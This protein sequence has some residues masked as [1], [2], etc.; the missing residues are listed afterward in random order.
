MSI[1]YWLVS[2]AVPHF[3]R[4]LARDHNVTMFNG[5]RMFQL[6][7]AGGWEPTRVH[8]SKIPDSVWRIHERRAVEFPSPDVGYELFPPMTRLPDKRSVPDCPEDTMIPVAFFTSDRLF[9]VPLICE[10]AERNNGAAYLHLEW[11]H[12]NDEGPYLNP[13]GES[14]GEGYESGGQ[15]LCDYLL[16]PLWEE[17]DETDFDEALQE[18]LFD[19]LSRQ[20]LME[21]SESLY[22]AWGEYLRD[23]ET[24]GAEAVEYGNRIHDLRKEAFESGGH[25]GLAYFNDT[26]RKATEYSSRHWGD[27]YHDSRQKRSY[28]LQELRTYLDRLLQHHTAANQPHQSV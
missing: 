22:R 1:E 18:F 4:R 9:I 12:D 17:C 11:D 25:E 8:Y 24:Q 15:E 6:L 19:R 14:F 7:F 13:K 16:P 3:T 23:L 20:A 10:V 26:L 27:S 21:A 2:E 28:I 5:A